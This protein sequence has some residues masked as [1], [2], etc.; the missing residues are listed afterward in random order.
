MN[1]H[2]SDSK[3]GKDDEITQ[4][5]ID[6]VVD[7]LK[8]NKEYGSNA[9]WSEN[10]II[11]SFA[12]QVVSDTSIMFDAW[13]KEDPKPDFEEYL[14]TKGWDAETPLAKQLAIEAHKVIFREQLENEVDLKL[15]EERK[16]EPTEPWN[17]V[18]KELD[19]KDE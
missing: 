7:S 13:E 9:H 3:I 5:M 15:I 18:K 1:Y 6:E 14:S 12:D 8:A 17:N 10:R 11:L 2:I 16:D 4:E 19:I